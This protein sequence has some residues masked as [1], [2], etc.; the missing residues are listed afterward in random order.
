MSKRKRNYQLTSSG[1]RCKGCPLHSKNRTQVTTETHG[2]K[3][4]ILLIAEAPGITENKTGR[5]VTG[6][7]GRIERRVVKQ[8]NGGSEKGIAYANIVRCRPTRRVKEKK[9]I[10]IIDRPPTDEEIR[11]CKKYLLRDIERINPQYIVL[12]G[13]IAAHTLACKPESNEVVESDT[14]IGQLRGLDYVVRTPNGKVYPATVTFHFANV[15]RNPKRGGVFKE[16]IQKAFIRTDP[17]AKDY[18][19]RGKETIILDTVSKVKKFL[20]RLQYDLTKKD[21][22]ALDYETAGLERINPKVLTIGFAYGPNKSF[23]IPYEH[24][25]TP[26]TG[27]EIRRIK[28]LL[29]KFFRGPVSFGALI[30]HNLKFEAAITKEAFG[31]SLLGITT[32]CTL[33]RSHSI[34]ENR[35]ILGKDP[36]SLKTLDREWLSFYHYSDP[37]IAPIVALRDVGRLSEAPLYELCQ[38]NGMDCYVEWRL[39]KYQ[40]YR[41]RQENYVKTLRRLHRKLKGPASVFAAQLER[42][43]IRINKPQIRFLRSEDSPILTRIAE[44]EKELYAFESCK[45]AND[46]L[47]EEESRVRGMRPLF[48]APWIFKLSKPRAKEL[49]YLNVLGLKPVSHT[50]KGKPQINKPFYEEHV[51]V[52]EVDLLAEWSGLEQIRGTYVEG[53]Y[54][55]LQSNPDMRDGRV[56][57]NLILGTT[58]TGRTS[59]NNPNMQ[60]I[61]KGKTEAAKSIKRLYVAAPGRLLVCMDY[62][63]AEVRWMAQI[64]RDSGLIKAFGLL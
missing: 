5:P 56:R 30:A 20:H 13:S 58:K 4:R 8:L 6:I 16:D 60:N 23:V 54:K 39:Y 45:N 57:G 51:G 48:Q 36:F 14:Q 10:K 34:N 62:S 15:S 47:L 31:V 63:Q 61:P 22:V 18:S 43:G 25:D 27:K 7:T 64:A 21:I 19:K 52:P 50:D 41:A 9:E 26:F 29:Q 38:Y 2:K 37:D 49:L 55:L 32:E 59:F 28:K 1:K 33:L 46:L 3:T 24:R 12:V 11:C 44:I 40:N 17:K 53:I 42:N 35:T